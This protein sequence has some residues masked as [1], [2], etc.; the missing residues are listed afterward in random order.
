MNFL[1]FIPNY[2]SKIHFLELNQQRCISFI[3]E[4]LKASYDVEAARTFYNEPDKRHEII[5]AFCYGDGKTEHLNSRMVSSLWSEFLT[6]E[7]N[8]QQIKDQIALIEDNRDYW[9]NLK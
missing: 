5:K 6:Y 9:M 1:P 4:I 7:Y 8:I 3:Y 2:Q